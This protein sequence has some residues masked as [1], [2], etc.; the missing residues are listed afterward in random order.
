MTRAKGE[1]IEARRIREV[2]IRRHLV[3]KNMEINSV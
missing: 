2:L 1:R 3:S